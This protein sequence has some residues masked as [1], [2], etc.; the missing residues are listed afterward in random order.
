MKMDTIALLTVKS[1]KN[2]FL[3]GTNPTVTWIHTGMI[4]LIMFRT[5]I[6]I[7]HS[8]PKSKNATIAKE[9]L[10]KGETKS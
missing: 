6:S 3:F 7:L 10:T 2:R 5:N 4:A 8:S 1:A 9:P